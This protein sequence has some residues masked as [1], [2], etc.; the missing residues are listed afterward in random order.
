MITVYL[1]TI[2]DLTDEELESRVVHECLHLHLNET[3]QPTD[4][5][6]LDHEERACSMVA[7]AFLTVRD[8]AKDGKL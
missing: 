8:W 4:G 5:D 2:A 6:W 3:R 1:G 7:R